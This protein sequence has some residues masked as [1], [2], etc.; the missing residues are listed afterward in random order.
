MNTPKEKIM[1]FDALLEWRHNMGKSGKKV[2][3]TNGCFDILHRGH[4]EYLFKARAQGDAMIVALNSDRSTRELKGPTRP[5]NDE[6][7]RALILSSLYF[8]DAVYI[9]DS[10]RCTLLFK[11]LMP[12]IYVKGADYNIDTIN[13]EEKASLQS[14]GSE[15]RFVEL[16]PGFSTTATIAKM[17]K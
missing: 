4:V 2:V 12:D 6:E 7:S 5:V 1:D 15:I 9:F 10:P 13:Q 8:V 11:S 16:T 14:V 17:A 3:V